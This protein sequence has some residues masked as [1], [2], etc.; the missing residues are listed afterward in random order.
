MQCLRLQNQTLSII[1]VAPLYKLHHLLIR[2]CVH[3]A[4]SQTF[5]SD[6][7]VSI[8]QKKLHI[9]I[10]PCW[11]NYCFGKQARNW[12]ALKY[13]TYVY[14][15]MY[16][17][18]FLLSTDIGSRA[19][20]MI[21][22]FAWVVAPPHQTAVQVAAAVCQPLTLGSLH[23]LS[24]VETLGRHQ[25]TCTLHNHLNA[26]FILFSNGHWPFGHSFLPCSRPDLQNV[27]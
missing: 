18:R 12:V 26:P 21:A 7:Y 6:P 10:C 3:Q 9:R 17:H 22:M 1:V 19:P 20:F 5:W 11:Y 25:L 2:S 15:Y 23:E 4:K 8:Q 27:L 24:P 14:T 13:Q 16:T